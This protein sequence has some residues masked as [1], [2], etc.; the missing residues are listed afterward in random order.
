MNS[1]R[2]RNHNDT[3][4]A[5]S[6]GV[7]APLTEPGRSHKVSAI[8]PTLEEA[9]RVRQHLIEAGIAASDVALLQNLPLPPD[10]GGND[11]VLKDMLVDGAIGTAVGTGVGAIGT[12][13]LWAGGV[14]LF[15]ASPVV[16]PLAMLGW[17]AGLGGLA[18]AVAGAAGQNNKKG[19]EGKFSELVMDAI[20]S[21]N[22]VLLVRTHGETDRALAKDI[23]TQSL[24]GHP[25]VA[26]ESS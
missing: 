12:A 20:T 17:F 1:P 2:N 5:P 15:V 23:I 11:E 18:G 25:T 10:E 9:E 7:A 24:T 26:T 19:K 3:S 13:M 21:G 16:A 22:V 6:P 14:T 4:A 8:Y